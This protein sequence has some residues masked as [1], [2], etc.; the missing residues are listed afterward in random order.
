MSFLNQSRFYCFEVR[1]PFLNHNPPHR[2][3]YDRLA[4]FMEEYIIG[5]ESTHEEI[6][7]T[8]TRANKY[9]VK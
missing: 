7:I 5:K 9:I 6:S 8:Y 4:D 2:L 1:A 3:C